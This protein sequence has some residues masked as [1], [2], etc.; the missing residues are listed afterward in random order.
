M[1]LG[2]V[3]SYQTYEYP[4]GVCEICANK[5]ILYTPKVKRCKRCKKAGYCIQCKKKGSAT[6][7]QTCPSCKTF[8]ETGIR[9]KPGEVKQKLEKIRP[10]GYYVYGW[11]FKGHMCPNYIGKG[12]GDRA[13]RSDKGASEVRIF[14]DNLTEEG[15]LLVESVLIELYL[16]DRVP[17]RNIARGIVRQEV[18]PLSL[19]NF[20]Q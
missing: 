20:E 10:R 1:T 16:E 4:R 5:I 13:W 6:Q 12:R 15:A 11:F 17:L 14:R 7:I 2:L 3:M 8:N 9:P 19:P 18:S